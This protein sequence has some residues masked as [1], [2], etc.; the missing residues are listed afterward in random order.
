MMNI[1][2]LIEQYCTVTV[3]VFP[4]VVNIMAVVVFVFT[5][6]NSSDDMQLC[7]PL[8][9]KGSYRKLCGFASAA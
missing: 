7:F 3:S 2:I 5:S 9:L 8:D 6:V 1:Q 4:V